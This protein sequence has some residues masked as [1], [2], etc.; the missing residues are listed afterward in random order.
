MTLSTKLA[1]A[2]NRVAL[3]SL[4]IPT[5]KYADRQLIHE[6]LAVVVLAAVDAC[7]K[8]PGLNRIA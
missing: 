1:R 7:N 4:M 6:R 3:N 2:K 8:L 5:M